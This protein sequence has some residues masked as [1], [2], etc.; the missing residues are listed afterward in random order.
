[1]EIGGVDKGFLEV[2]LSDGTGWE[3]LEPVPPASPDGFTCYIH[4]SESPPFRCVSRNI[5]VLADETE[6]YSWMIVAHLP[7]RRE[8]SLSWDKSVIPDYAVMTIAGLNVEDETPTSGSLSMSETDRVSCFPSYAS[9]LAW[10]LEAT[11]R[12]RPSQ[13][14]DGDL[15]ADD[16]ERESF[17]AAPCDPGDDPDGDGLS[18]YAE[19]MAGTDPTDHRSTLTISGI[20]RDV[21]DDVTVLAWESVLGRKYQLFYCDSI[22]DGNWQ[23][24]AEEVTGTGGTMLVP[25]AI[26]YSSV[27]KRF[28]CIRV[29]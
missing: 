1:M 12:A 27:S 15:I 6:R 21:V 3:T 2:G 10:K 14:A 11:F 26:P 5:A 9:V 4:G 28:Y 25:D 7:G 8:F 20:D 18:N 19:F 24:L 29:W 23:C 17:G 22:E 16:W 13:D